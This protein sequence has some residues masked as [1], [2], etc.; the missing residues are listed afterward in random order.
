MPASPETVVND[1]NG[2]IPAS[3]PTRRQWRFPPGDGGHG[4]RFRPRLARSARRDHDLQRLVDQVRTKLD[5]NTGRHSLKVRYDSITS[6]HRLVPPLR[7]LTD[8]GN[9]VAFLGDE[10]EKSLIVRIGNFRCSR[11]QP[12]VITRGSS[13]DRLTV[14]LIQK[15][16][17][18]VGLDR[19]DVL[20]L[21]RVVASV[22]PAAPLRTN[23]APNPPG[24]FSP[25]NE[26]RAVRRPI[27]GREPP[28]R[29]PG[30][31]VIG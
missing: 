17:A 9:I 23:T 8:L 24:D 15:D 14:R 6:W 22:L 21:V 25:G 1:R 5:S 2:R 7:Y 4:A 29:S 11:H 30:F 10:H 3:S 16:D 28:L 20:L 13:N 31:P 18:I 27:P 19:P 12:H 26:V